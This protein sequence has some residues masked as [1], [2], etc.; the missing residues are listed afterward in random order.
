MPDWLDVRGD[1]V[2]LRLRVQ[3]RASRTEV[4]GEHGGALK[5]RVSAPPVDG[6]AN[7]ELERFLARLVGVARSQVRVIGGATGRAK[8]VEIEGAEPGKIVRAL[9]GGSGA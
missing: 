5:V 2:R 7:A 4:V 9:T 6:S 3:P 8:V 1:T